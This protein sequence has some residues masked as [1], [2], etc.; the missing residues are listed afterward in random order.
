MMIKL[1][2]GQK[3]FSMINKDV[4]TNYLYPKSFLQEYNVVMGTS[5]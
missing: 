5:P 1:K 4:K 3:L 2:Q